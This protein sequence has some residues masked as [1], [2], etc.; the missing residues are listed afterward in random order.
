MPERLQTSYLSKASSCN[1]HNWDKSLRI[2]RYYGREI[3]IFFIFLNSRV[4]TALKNTAPV[5]FN[6]S[7]SSTRNSSNNCQ[8]DANVLRGELMPTKYGSALNMSSCR[9]MAKL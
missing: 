1:I 9:T 6:L 2:S 4:K 3:S 5:F 8:A 7:Y